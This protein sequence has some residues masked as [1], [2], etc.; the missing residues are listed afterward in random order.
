MV[1]RGGPILWILWVLGHFIVLNVDFIGSMDL[2]HSK[3]MADDYRTCYCRYYGCN[4]RKISRFMFQRHS[5]KDNLLPPVFES[6]EMPKKSSLL[7]KADRKLYEGASENQTVLRSVAKHVMIH[8]KNHGFTQKAMDEIFKTHKF[9]LPE[10]NCFPSNWREAKGMLKDSIVPL[11]KYDCCLND[12]MIYRKV[13]G[14][15]DYS[16][17]TECPMCHEPRYKNGTKAANKIFTYMPIKQRLQ[18]YFGDTNISRLLHTGKLNGNAAEIMKDFQDGK[19]FRSWFST[20]GIFA[21]NADAS[22]PLGLFADGQ[23]PNRDTN[24]CRSMWPL[25]VTLFSLP[26]EYRTVLGPLMVIGVIPGNPETGGEPL[27][28]DPYVEVFVDEILE[29]DGSVMYSSLKGKSVEVKASLLFI[30]ADLPAASKLCHTTGCQGL[31]GCVFCD[32]KASYC[33]ELSKPVHLHNR[34]FLPLEH[35][36]RNDPSFGEPEVLPPPRRTTEE[37]ELKIRNKFKS[38]KTQS[39]RSQCVKEGGFKGDYPLQ[40]LKSKGFER[41]RA[42]TTDPMHTI[43][44]MVAHVTHTIRGSED[45]GKV[46]KCEEAFNRFPDSWLSCA[47]P[48]K[49]RR[50]DTSSKYKVSKYKAK[51]HLPPAPWRLTERGLKVA[52]RRMKRI[53]FPSWSDLRS[54]PCFSK[55]RFLRNMHGKVEVNIFYVFTELNNGDSKVVLQGSCGYFWSQVETVKPIGER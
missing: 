8:I 26:P 6:N 43:A 41:S 12:C 4:G 37:I 29:I 48:S 52:D 10:G 20:E 19:S 16:K 50:I 14:G 42:T 34:R 15:A 21:D 53:Q 46:R 38:C 51:T 39:Q 1:S 40:K 28:L 9:D 24:T 47:P 49:K 2:K 33:K 55:P 45:G 11:K 27:S 35:P 31:S 54:K 30:T 18:R 23:N 7:Q 36:F 13:L 44:D 22:F 5:E 17:L 3:I 32:N 25:L